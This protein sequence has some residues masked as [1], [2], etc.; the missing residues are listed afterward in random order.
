MSAALNSTSIT[1][2]PRDVGSG[3]QIVFE[4]NNPVTAVGAATTLDSAMVAGIGAPTVTFSG[5]EVTVTLTGAV[6]V[7]KRLTISL[8]GVNGSGTASVNVGFLMGDL[9]NS[10]S[11][12]AGD[13]LLVKGKSGQG[14]NLSNFTFDID[15][16]G[17]TSAGDILL[18][19]GRSG[20]ALAP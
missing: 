5:N 11:V 14:A 8:S 18:V 10:R 19:K 16:S 12:S 20:Q 9:D 4:F 3:H 1:V 17:A 15:A 7:N 13:I 2:E 6:L